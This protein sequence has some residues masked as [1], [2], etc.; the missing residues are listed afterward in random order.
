MKN[1]QILLSFLFSTLFCLSL[2]TSITA[3]CENWVNS[4]NKEDAETAH[5]LYRQEVKNK[6]YDG[7]YDNW[8]KAYELAPAADGKRP[9]HYADGRKILMHKYDNEADE[10]KKKELADFILKLYNQ[11]ME[12]YGNEAALLGFKAYDMFY[13]FRSPYTDTYEILSEAMKK[14]GKSAPYTVMDPMATRF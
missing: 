8:M 7:A 12:C 4:P 6:N 1:V 3:Q 10:A 13:K 14:G 9:S 11:Q 2:T 5:V